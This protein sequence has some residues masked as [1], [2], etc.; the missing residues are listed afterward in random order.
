MQITRNMGVVPQCEAN[1]PASFEALK[2]QKKR[3]PSHR[4][5]LSRLFLV[6]DPV[7]GNALHKL[8]AVLQT[9]E[10]LWS[11]G[12]SGLMGNSRLLQRQEDCNAFSLFKLAPLASWDRYN[13]GESRSTSSRLMECLRARNRVMTSCH[14]PGVIRTTARQTSRSKPAA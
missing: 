9:I 10:A 7:Q 4:F 3:G 2:S 13:E 5:L 6:G 14:P 11:S 12:T 1:K 8:T